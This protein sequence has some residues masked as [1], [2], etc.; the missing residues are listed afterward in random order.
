VLKG[1]WTAQ[2]AGPGTGEADARGI[3]EPFHLINGELTPVVRAQELDEKGKV[4]DDQDGTAET[5]LLMYRF[6]S[7]ASAITLLP[8]L[9]V[10]QACQ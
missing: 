5:S 10:T 6:S 7:I 1:T 3:A 8:S 2:N 4:E 9:L